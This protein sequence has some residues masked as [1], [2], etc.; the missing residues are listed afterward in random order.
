[1]SIESITILANCNTDTYRDAYY[2][3]SQILLSLERIESCAATIANAP[4]AMYTLI[5]LAS[6]SAGSP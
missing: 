3:T 4:Y 6:W 1:M 5:K 2:I